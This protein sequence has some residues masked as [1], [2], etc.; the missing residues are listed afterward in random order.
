MN[1]QSMRFP[2]LGYIVYILLPVELSL[3]SV[4]MGPASDISIYELQ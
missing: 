3:T 2:L 4:A 1:V